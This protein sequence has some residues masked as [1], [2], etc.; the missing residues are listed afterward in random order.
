MYPNEN[1]A[2]LTQLN[3]LIV[4]GWNLRRK[5][6]KFVLPTFFLGLRD[7][8]GVVTPAI[9]GRLSGIDRDIGKFRDSNKNSRP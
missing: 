4:C 3:I 9:C 5:K 2:I 8:G 1:T 7:L 6:Y